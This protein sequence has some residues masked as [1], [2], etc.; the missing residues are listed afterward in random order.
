LTLLLCLA[1]IFCSTAT[2]LRPCFGRRENEK[3]EIKIRKPMNVFEQT[4]VQI[5]A[6]VSVFLRWLYSSLWSCPLSYFNREKM[7]SH[8]YVRQKWVFHM[9]EWGWFM[10]LLF[11]NT[12][13]SSSAQFPFSH[14]VFS[15]LQDDWIVRWLQLAHSCEDSPLRWSIRSLPS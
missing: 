15:F 5:H 4:F 1:T 11:H 7:V 2:S 6:L 14:P 8:P 13:G 3:R 10:T 12:K 9:V